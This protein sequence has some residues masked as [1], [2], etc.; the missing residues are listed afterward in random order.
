VVV[1]GDTL[2]DISARFLETPW[3]WP[4]LWGMNEQIDNPH[5]IYPGDTIYLV[6]VDGKPQLRLKRGII[7]L[8]PG[9]RAQP[10]ERAIP[11]LPLR[12]LAAFLKDTRVVDDDLYQQSPYVIGGRNERIIAGAGDRVYAR[13]ELEDERNTKQG[14]YRASQSYVDPNTGELLGYELLK[15][16]DVS[17]AAQNESVLSLDINRS[18][19]EL[20]VLDRV[21]PIEEEPIRSMFYPKP[22][23]AELEGTI[24]SVVGAVRDGGQFD[25]VAINL[26][27]RE[28]VTPGDVFA[29]YRQGETIIDPV[30]KEEITL[31]SERSGLVMIFKVFDKVSYGLIMESTNVVSEGD[32][33]R[34][35]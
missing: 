16:A 4:E 5:L 30:T 32:Q 33:L 11:S 18:R 25:V 23:P 1:K 15:I 35:P 12:D 31:P 9:V 21:I 19:M 22:A 28:L 27:D 8:Q 6:W 34:Q 20:R 14:I 24:L 10:L 17:V 26:G 2:W 13:G 3:K 7:K 29:I